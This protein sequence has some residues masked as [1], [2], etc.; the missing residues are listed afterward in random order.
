MPR[1]IFTYGSLMFSQV[2]QRVVRG[3]YRSARAIV[4]GYARYAIVAETYPA[5]IAQAGATVSGILYFDVH[6]Q[7]IA[8]LDAFEGADYRRQTVQVQSETGELY[9]ADT[10]IYL[11]H[12][13][14]TT[15]SWLP[16]SFQLQ[17][18]LMTY[19]NLPIIK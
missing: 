3:N 12:S 16:D 9:A 1:H 19:G 13:R 14:V 8:I 4:D 17:Q 10:F 6:E 7:D 2:W 18:F 11:E 15:A 5:M